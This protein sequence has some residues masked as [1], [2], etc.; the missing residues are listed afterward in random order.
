M[1]FLVAKGTNRVRSW[2]EFKCL[3]KKVKPS[4]LV[5]VLEQYGFS[6]EKELTI[7]RLIMPSEETYCL[8][9]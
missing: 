1:F 6:S 3:A 9:F 8:F 7:L 2:N 5:Y 4:S